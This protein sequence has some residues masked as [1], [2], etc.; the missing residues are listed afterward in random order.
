MDGFK[1]TFADVPQ[2]IIENG[3][4]CTSCTPFSRAAHGAN[5]SD[6]CIKAIFMTTT[7]LYVAVCTL[8][9]TRAFML[10]ADVLM[11]VNTTRFWVL[12]RWGD[13]AFF[14]ERCGIYFGF[15]LNVTPHGRSPINSDKDFSMQIGSSGCYGDG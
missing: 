5:L 14:N 1:R 10:I 7:S 15:Y 12:A 9:T 8:N 3:A 2:V 6:E 11:C 13:G 4:D